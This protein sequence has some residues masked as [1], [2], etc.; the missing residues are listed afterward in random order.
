MN[1]FLAQL[2]I[3]FRRDP[4]NFRPRINKCVTPPPQVFLELPPILLNDD[5][6]RLLSFLPFGVAVNTYTV[7]SLT[8]GCRCRLAV[9]HHP[10]R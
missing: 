9:S 2:E 3:T 1:Q 6:I 4:T 8:K 10:L 5:T 7:K